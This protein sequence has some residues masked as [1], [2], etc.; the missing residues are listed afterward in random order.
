MNATKRL[1]V[2]SSIGS[3]MEELP[4]KTP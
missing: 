1:S 2:H 3:E 4:P